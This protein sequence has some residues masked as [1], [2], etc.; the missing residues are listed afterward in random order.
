MFAGGEGDDAGS[1]D[2][3]VDADDD[4]TDEED[5]EEEALVAPLLS[6]IPEMAGEAVNLFSNS[7]PGAWIAHCT[8]MHQQRKK[9]KIN[10][11]TNSEAKINAIVLQVPHCFVRIR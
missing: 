1:E 8:E 9:R 4:E 2:A 7:E 5:D 3:G 6:T 10:K 11:R